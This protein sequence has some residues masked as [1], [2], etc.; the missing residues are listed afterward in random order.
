ML[1]RGC[2]VST[3]SQIS[4][5]D[6]QAN[7]FL[8]AETSSEIEERRRCFVASRCWLWLCCLRRIVFEYDPAER[9]ML[10]SE[11]MLCKEEGLASLGRAS[12]TSRHLVAFIA[13]SLCKIFYDSLHRILELSFTPM[14]RH[15]GIPLS[16]HKRIFWK[17]LPIEQEWR[18][19]MIPLIC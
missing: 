9:E 17:M 13:Y 8:I 4:S 14:G 19:T 6:V 11:L 3:R 1:Y 2:C 15:K 10:E 18:K 5:S 12:Y 7:P 16:M